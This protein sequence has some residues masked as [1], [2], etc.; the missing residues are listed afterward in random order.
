[1]TD[2]KKG[3]RVK[4]KSEVAKMVVL[5]DRMGTVASNNKGK[6]VGIIWDGL[7]SVQ[8]WD[9]SYLEKV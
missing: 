5:P 3:D 1:M 6:T 2:F 4:F 8:R 7:K 9:K